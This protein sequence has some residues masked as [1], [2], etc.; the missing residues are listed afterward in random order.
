LNNSLLMA[1]IFPL[2]SVIIII[3]FAGGLGISFM[4]LEHYMHNEIGIIILGASL[5]VGVPS[6]AALLQIKI[7]KSE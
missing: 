6:F 3:I 1:I 7:E 4:L 2:L 5:V